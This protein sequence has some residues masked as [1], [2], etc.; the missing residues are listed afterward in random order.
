MGRKNRKVLLE[1]PLFFLGGLRYS[2]FSLSLSAVY[3]WTN[4]GIE[5]TGVRYGKSWCAWANVW[6]L[7]VSWERMF[8]SSYP[9]GFVLD[10]WFSNYDV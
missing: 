8:I 5:M 10:F 3:Q 2:P 7:L 1:L 4:R 6:Y 9:E